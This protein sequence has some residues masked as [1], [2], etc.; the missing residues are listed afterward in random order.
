MPT[1]SL[2]LRRTAGHPVSPDIRGYRRC[3]GLGFPLWSVQS[4]LLCVG[5]VSV[6]GFAADSVG[7]GV[8]A[9][10]LPVFREECVLVRQHDCL[11]AVAEVEFLEDVR[12]VGLDRGVTDVELLGDLAV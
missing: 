3:S 12:D 5:A 8:V 9:A 1:V 11:D 10:A 2:M 7:G 6:V 4:G